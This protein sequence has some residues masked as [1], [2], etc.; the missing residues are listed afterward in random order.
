METFK[1]RQKEMQ[2]LD[3]QREK[4]AKRKERTARRAAGIAD[5]PDGSEDTIAD[6]SPSAA[7]TDVPLTT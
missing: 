7:E 3:R 4:A 5:P 1:K 2:R 6:A